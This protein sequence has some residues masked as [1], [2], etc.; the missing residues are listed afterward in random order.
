[1]SI[2]EFLSLGSAEAMLFVHNHQ[3]QVSELNTLLYQGVSADENRN[4]A[5]GDPLEELIARET[6]PAA[7]VDF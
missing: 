6:C 1:M 5:G 2:D 7:G 4:L 3:R